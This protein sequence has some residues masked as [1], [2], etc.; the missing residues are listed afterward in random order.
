MNHSQIF[1][2]KKIK[3]QLQEGYK[4]VEAYL[5]N[6]FPLIVGGESITTEDKINSI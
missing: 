2:K 5:G 6:D 3:K 1:Q 4:V